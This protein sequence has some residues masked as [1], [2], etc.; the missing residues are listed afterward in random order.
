MQDK[1]RAEVSKQLTQKPAKYVYVTNIMENALCGFSS[2]ARRTMILF[3]EKRAIKRKK[4]LVNKVNL[5][6][7]QKKEIKDF[8]VKHY[9]K[10]VPFYWH[11]LY[12]SYTGNY[13]YNYFPE[14]L[15]STKLEQKLNPYR[16]AEF[17]SDKNLLETFFGS[18]EG[19]HIPKTF[20]SCIKGRF[21]TGDMQITTREEAERLLSDIGRCVLKKTTETCSGRDVAI[22]D[23]K[24]GVDERSGITI[25]ELLCQFGS[26]F[27]VQ[28]F[29]QQFAPLAAIN[30]SSVNTF[31][32]ATY[33][34]E[35]KIYHCSPVLRL[36]RH[37][38]E[39]DNIHFGGV[40][41]PISEDGV[42]N[43]RAFSEQGEEFFEHPDSHIVFSGYTIP[44]FADVIKKAHEL[45]ARIPYLG[46]VSWD[47]SLDQDGT[48]VLIE[49][50]TYR[51]SAGICQRFAGVPLFGDNTAKMLE[52]IRK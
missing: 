51:Q 28:E 9:G 29:I 47:F 49:V 14:I 13:C 4:A 36:G 50:N 45:H 52:L 17:L 20:L 25:S 43:D 26:N 44:G 24:N 37:G 12:Q 32:V 48:P 11:R 2:W 16:E 7:E 33:I 19:L 35:G 6:K 39:K 5:T 38:H 42:L 34:L 40:G 18:V 23:F 41:V 10:S 3:G 31:R 15:F 27:V 1:E 46:F 22:C 21:R 8:F 30:H